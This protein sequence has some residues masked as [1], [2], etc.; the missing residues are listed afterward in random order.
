MSF[1]PAIQL[2]WAHWSLN[3]LVEAAMASAP[4]AGSALVM[5][6]NG[7]NVRAALWMLDEENP[8]D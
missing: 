6:M 5:R 1:S 8:D 7:D 2:S 3:K 4:D